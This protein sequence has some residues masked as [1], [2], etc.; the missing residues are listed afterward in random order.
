MTTSSWLPTWRAGGTDVD[1]LFV[2]NDALAVAELVRTRKLGA[3]ELLAGTLANLRKINADLNAITDFYDDAPAAAEG[4]F[5]VP[6][7]SGPASSLTS[8]SS[9]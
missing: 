4:P 1:N 7:A 6:S 5:S 9:A 8:V 3:Q 2:D